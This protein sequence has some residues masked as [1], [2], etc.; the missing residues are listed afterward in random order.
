MRIIQEV[1]RNLALSTAVHIYLLINNF[2]QYEGLLRRMGSLWFDCVTKLPGITRIERFYEALEKWRSAYAIYTI[3]I[4]S[5]W[6]GW[7][8]S[9]N[10]RNIDVVNIWADTLRSIIVTHTAITTVPLMI[11]PCTVIPDVFQESV[12]RPLLC[13][14]MVKHLQGP[15]WRYVFWT[16]SRKQ[17]K[18]FDAIWY[19]GII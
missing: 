8:H 15:R 19:G 6:R 7:K 1:S 5:I 2:L 9:S 3:I 17:L 14:I 10:N 12:R 13:S 11:R 18:A 4:H 16:G